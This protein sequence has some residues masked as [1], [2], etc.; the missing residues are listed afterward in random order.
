MRGVP[1]R[2]RL[3]LAFAAVMAVVLAAA[4]AFVYLRLASGLDQAI[5]DGLRARAD[6]VAALVKSAS[7]GL[8]GGEGLAESG[9]SFAQVIDAGGRVVDTTPQLGSTSLLRSSDLARA[10]RGTIFVGHGPLPI[11]DEPSRLLATPVEAA[12]RPFVVVVGASLEGRREALGGLRTQLL[13]GGPL[14]L[15]VASLAGYALA[16]AALRPV[17]SMRREAAA[18]SAAEPGRRLPVPPTN[19]EIRRLGE[20]LNEM[21]ARL[22]GAL[23]RERRFVADASHELRT[24][25]ALLKAELELALR[26]DRTADEL[27]SAIRSAAGET[28]RLVRLAEDLLV[29]AR[30]DRGALTIRREPVDVRELLEAVADRF[31][32]RAADVGRTIQVEAPA[33][34]VVGAD[35]MRLEQALG[36]LVDNALTHGAGRVELTASAEAAGTRLT[37]RDG[38]AGFSEDFLPQAFGR[39]TRPDQ[40]RTG[41]GSGLGLAIVQVIAG[42]HGGT[43]QARNLAADGAEVT[44][45][46]P[47]A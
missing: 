25:L 17:E 30:S 37:V 39:F 44:L 21:L 33:G 46:L 23:E 26:R 41:E 31:R 18:I 42:A 5:D 24:P 7:G 34:L 9:E 29:L 40:A 2:I 20:T 6:A 15:L 47:G 14:A 45:E 38:G 8:S 4:G 28:D 27:E 22:E 1:I 32:P 12:G 3:T 13:V 36:N 16:A 19:D 10:R 43:A 35:R 11:V